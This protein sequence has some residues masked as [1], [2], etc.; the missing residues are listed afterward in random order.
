ML[1][2]TKEQIEK[3][4]TYRSEVSFMRRCAKVTRKVVDGQIIEE[5][6]AGD[7]GCVVAKLRDTLTK[8]LWASAIGP[9]SEKALELVLEDVDPSQIP[10]TPAEV[11][12]EVMALRKEVAELKGGTPSTPAKTKKKAKAPATPAPSP[13]VEPDL[14]PGDMAAALK[15]RGLAVPMGDRAHPQ[16]MEQAMELLRGQPQTV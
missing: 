6:L 13:D 10:M 5:I 12:Q 1:R 8:K 2:M 14:N 15:S 7:E 16:W 9:T 3:L 4:D 11:Q